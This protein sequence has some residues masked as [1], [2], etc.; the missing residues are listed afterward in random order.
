MRRRDLKINKTL[1]T[2]AGRNGKLY[3]TGAY[4]LDDRINCEKDER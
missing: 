2:K 4:S 3:E 1:M